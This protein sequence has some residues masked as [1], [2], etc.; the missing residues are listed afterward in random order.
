MFDTLTFTREYIE[1]IAGCISAF[2]SISGRALFQND[3]SKIRL[4]SFDETRG[5]PDWFNNSLHTVAHW[6]VALFES[7]I[8]RMFLRK[9][10]DESFT[11]V[12]PKMVREFGV[13][14]QSINTNLQER[15]IDRAIEH[16]EAYHNL[17]FKDNSIEL[18]GSLLYR[19][20]KL[21]PQTEKLLKL[22][23]NL[24]RLDTNDKSG[25][26]TDLKIKVRTLLATRPIEEVLRDAF[27]VREKGLFQVEW[28]VL[29]KFAQIVQMNC[30]HE[31]CMKELCEEGPKKVGKQ[32]GKK[33]QGKQLSRSNSPKAKPAS[34]KRNPDACNSLKEGS[35]KSAQMSGHL[36]GGKAK[37]KDWGKQGVAKPKAE[38]K[39]VTRFRAETAPSAPVQPM[40]TVTGSEARDIDKLAEE[41]VEAGTE[42]SSPPLQESKDDIRASRSPSPIPNV[43]AVL[44]TP[45]THLSDDLNSPIVGTTP[46][47]LAKES[48]SPVKPP[49]QT[50]PS[51]NTSAN[52]PAPPA[53]TNVNFPEN[54]LLDKNL[55][56]KPLESLDKLEKKPISLCNEAINDTVA[57][58]KR[59]ASTHSQRKPSTVRQEPGHYTEDFS[60]SVSQTISTKEE[61]RAFKKHSGQPTNAHDF[62]EHK[63]EDSEYEDDDYEFDQQELMAKKQSSDKADEF[64]RNKSSEPKHHVFFPGN[65]DIKMNLLAS[66]TQK[67]VE[68]EYGVD[69]VGGMCLPMG[70]PGF[71]FGEP[72]KRG[73]G[74]PLDRT[75]FVGL[76]SQKKTLAGTSARL[77]FEFNGHLSHREGKAL[78]KGRLSQGGIFGERN[79]KKWSENPIMVGGN[80]RWTD[81]EYQGRA[82]DPKP[83]TSN[84]TI[85]HPVPTPGL[86]SSKTVPT[87]NPK[88][89]NEPANIPDAP[90]N[91][92][93]TI[94]TFPLSQPPE[95]QTKI[96]P[97][98]A[99]SAKKGASTITPGLSIMP[100]SAPLREVAYTN[101][102]G[103]DQPTPPVKE[104]PKKLKKKPAVTDNSSQTG[105]SIH[106][107]RKTS[108]ASQ[109]GP[110]K[111]DHDHHGA[112]LGSVDHSHPKS[113]TL[114]DREKLFPGLG[115]L[116]SNPVTR[117]YLSNTKLRSMIEMSLEPIIQANIEQI[118]KSLSV[119][120]QNLKSG[121]STA[122]RQLESVVAAVFPKRNFKCVEFGS[123]ATN[124]VTPFSDMDIG[125]Q[126][127]EGG[128]RT[129]SLEILKTL[130]TSLR[131]Q[132]WVASLTPIYTASI[133]VLKIVCAAAPQISSAQIPAKSDDQSKV[134]VSPLIL[135]SQEV[136]PPLP[137][138]HPEKSEVK[139][140]LIV[141]ENEPGYSQ[142]SAVRTTEFIKNCLKRSPPLSRIN[143]L[144]K[145]IL[146]MFQLTNS[147]QGD[148][149]RRTVLVR[150]QSD[151]SRLPDHETTR[152]VPQAGVDPP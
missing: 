46:S 141:L 18:Q 135:P 90:P 60:L 131:D 23:L 4:K 127:P 130:E 119:S 112:E 26:F 144:I 52:K 19:D 57:D 62:T 1:D 126:T 55:F 82:S 41:T 69:K 92:P 27:E 134:G 22:L 101:E 114:D 5:M 128:D 89:Q 105:S 110:R 29:G 72:G 39:G 132:P 102:Y 148:F 49:Q 2:D 48:D 152:P 47:K 73:M 64:T 9:E 115:S 88:S 86:N 77:G 142:S 8:I 118:L 42:K 108:I 25:F 68:K 133:P 44:Q 139:I 59:T 37:V 85:S 14:W 75:K 31:K 121:F 12:S 103:L 11:R 93:K 61:S 79:P 50:L 83:S 10:N 74:G 104:K 140:D 129:R 100:A 51:I 146:N 43:G 123:V 107:A 94:E 63:K 53:R 149:T 91:P 20:F 67:Q 113:H 3:F 81:N 16:F 80:L 111:W 21:I 87:A 145:Y 96:N 106:D 33:G 124:L 38:A 84:L 122:K 54:F 99:G 71:G 40:I 24:A 6:L 76:V 125:I 143:L 32:K 151:H 36:K 13:Y 98:I 97:E 109:P 95:P 120:T 137:G 15:T 58:H 45:H 70:A 17:V 34:L 136:N 150:P 65:N 78:G 56:K 147:Y 66:A 138:T 28:F 35:L 30:Y 116:R 117:S 7:R